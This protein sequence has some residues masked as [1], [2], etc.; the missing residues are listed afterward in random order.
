MEKILTEML[1]I[2]Q[3]LLGHHRQLLDIVRIER[4]HL[5]QVNHLAIQTIIVRKQNEIEAIGQIETQR[6]KLVSDLGQ[7]LGKSP[8]DL[9]LPKL[10]IEVQA[11]NPKL[12]EQ[13]RSTYNALTVLIQR[14][15][16][17]NRDNQKLLQR[18][19]ENIYE[20]KKNILGVASGNAGT[21]SQQGQRVTGA[22]PR[23]L[24]SR[25]A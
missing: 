11:S 16:G 7:L 23:H 1:H 2:L 19:I 12:A 10:I 18:S 6:V 14:I 9:T 3:K 4:E 15:T 17:Q 8:T 5:V 13:F 21:Y 25:E 20:M 22:S 24:I